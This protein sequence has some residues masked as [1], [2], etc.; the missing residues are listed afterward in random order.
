MFTTHHAW[1]LFS[2][3]L[4]SFHA[5]LYTQSSQLAIATYR[6]RL[7]YQN[8]ILLSYCKFCLYTNSF[9]IRFYQVSTLQH[10]Q[11]MTIMKT[12]VQKQKL[13]IVFHLWKMLVHVAFF[14][15]VLIENLTLVK[16]SKLHFTVIL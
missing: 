9:I 8:C 10:F 2:M 11:A 16:L 5:H 13:F 3:A 15:K 1:V 7:S 4:D 6:H 12:E 14:S